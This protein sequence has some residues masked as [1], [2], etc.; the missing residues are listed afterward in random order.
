M[1]P[2]SGK[3]SEHE[4]YDGRITL[5]AANGDELYG[6]YDYPAIDDGYPIVFNGGTGRFANATGEATSSMT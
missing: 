3:D 1:V 2:L 6:V 5:I 4:P